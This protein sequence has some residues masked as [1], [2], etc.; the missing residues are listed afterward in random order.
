MNISIGSS[1]RLFVR[2]FMAWYCH[3]GM[4]PIYCSPKTDD[5]PKFECGSNS[6]VVNVVHWYL[7]MIEIAVI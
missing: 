2:H 1:L 4:A 3:L 7:I 5:H 6:V